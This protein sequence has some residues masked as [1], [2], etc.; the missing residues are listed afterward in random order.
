MSNP[1]YPAH[2]PSNLGTPAPALGKLGSMALGA[3]AKPVLQ[4]SPAPDSLRGH[5]AARQR[6]V[7]RLTQV[8]GIQTPAVLAAMAAVERHGF[9]DSAL[10]GQ[11]Y[12]DTSLPIGFSQTISKPQVVARML[13][14]LL[15]VPMPKD[16]KVLEIGTGCGYQAAVLAQAF[17]KVYSIERISGLHHKAHQNLL[18]QHSLGAQI[19]GVHLILGDG[20]LGYKPAAPYHA[21]IAAAGGEELPPAW[22]EQLAVGG[23]IVA[24][25]AQGA[26]GQQALVVVD[27]AADG[28][29]QRQSLDAVHFVP[30]KS[31][32]L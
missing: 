15:Q 20:M 32:L 31:G 18:A 7:Q 4:R 26:G 27:K 19:A 16:A 8:H 28:S 29:V 13:Q 6:M 14:L 25:V 1:I 24:P 21:I 2:A 11:A 3:L 5:A 30:L 22:L 12:E 10:I 23:R 17:S 9:V